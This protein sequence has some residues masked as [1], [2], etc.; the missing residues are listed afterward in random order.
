VRYERLRRGEEG[1]RNEVRK[2]IR[3]MDFEAIVLDWIEWGWLLVV[4]RGVLMLD[5][6]LS[7]GMESSRSK[8]G[9]SSAPQVPLNSLVIARSIE[10]FGKVLSTDG[11]V[12]LW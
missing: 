9:Q 8:R 1:F 2:A 5:R 11:G 12:L 4:W 3:D 10:I 6:R 7:N